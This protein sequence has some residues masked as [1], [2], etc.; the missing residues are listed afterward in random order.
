M[1]LLFFSVAASPPHVILNV[2][3]DLGHNDLGYSSTAAPG[4]DILTPNIDALAASG[5][6]LSDY[7][8]FRFCSPSRSTFLT[9]RLPYHVGQ[10]TGLN[11][12]PTPGI[13]CGIHTEYAYLPELLSRAGYVSY[14]LGKWHVGFYNNSQTPTYRGFSSYLGCAHSHAADRPRVTPPGLTNA[15][16]HAGT[17]VAR[18]STSRTRRRAAG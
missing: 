12:N 16:A 7:N 11:L 14:A 6:K 15:H 9:G 2:V 1:A 18:K 3:D 13:A 4:S 10:Q 17:T 5:V 8:V